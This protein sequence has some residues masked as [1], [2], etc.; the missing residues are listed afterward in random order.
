MPVPDASDAR[1]LALMQW[2]DLAADRFEKAWQASPPPNLADFLG[3]TS[4]ERRI[5]LLC[6]LVKIDVA[7][8]RK[9]DPSVTPDDYRQRFPEL[10]EQKRA[11]AAAGDGASPRP[12]LGDLSTSTESPVAATP[13][14]S[15]SVTIGGYFVVGKLDEGGQS[16]VYRAFHRLLAREVVIKLSREPFA[17]D[18]AAR[19]VL[20]AEGRV[21]AELDHPNLAHV[22]DVGF[23]EC[24][25][26]LV[27]EFIRG[28]HLGQYMVQARPTPRQAAALLAPVARALAAAHRR[29]ITH[30]DVKPK[31]IVIDD[32][33]RPRL[34]DFGLALLRHAW[35]EDPTR[36]RVA[37]GTPPY[38]AP[39]QACGQAERVGPASDIFG[40][41][42]VLYHLLT[43]KAP[44]SAPSVQEALARAQEC[45]V[46][47]DRLRATR[48]PRRLKAICLRALAADPARRPASA[49]VLANDLEAAARPP[50]RWPWLAAGV[51][52][53]TILLAALAWNRGW[54]PFRPTDPQRGT[55][56]LRANALALPVAL[57]V[58]VWRHGDPFLLSE[59]VP[60]M[61]R[62]EL[63]VRAGVPARMS[64]ALF[65]VNGAGRLR[66]LRMFAAGDSAA[67][68]H[69]PDVEKTVALE[70]PSGTELVFLIAREG[71]PPTLEEV[72][73]LWGSAGPWPQLP[74]HSLLRIRPDE[75]ELTGERARDFGA[76][77]NRPD[78][79]DAVL[80]DRLDTFRL[81]LAER[82]PVFEGVAFPHQERTRRP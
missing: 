28:R 80:R 36:P 38:M 22:Y 51:T 32:K 34:I 54:D 23:H 49:D 30:R 33:D 11:S 58:K 78:A 59:A 27:I 26:Y 42:A 31:N 39:E 72:A 41:G 13:G 9:T 48:A 57:E 70:G 52:A 65:L 56:G 20:L 37:C 45:D 7:Y 46:D 81:R 61:A 6:E 8:R 47:R 55:S 15:D 29:G 53:V 35:T 43:G 40:L 82:Y 18:D 63:K 14:L 76:I 10:K 50:A 71:P 19:D 12:D 24:R 73:A 5:A 79:A 77:R 17:G 44:F 69:F 62:D 16:V 68:V 25:P 64:A 60:L 21:L 2:V 1:S 4:G 74:D 3:D 75:V 67:V 66:L